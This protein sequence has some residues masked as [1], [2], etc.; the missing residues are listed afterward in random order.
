LNL[1]ELERRW[2]FAIKPALVRLRQMQAA[3]HRRRFVK[4]YIAVTGSCGK[5]TT[6]ALAAALLGEFGSATASHPNA[7]TKLLR[8]IRRINAPVDFFVQ[9]TSAHGPGAIDMTTRAFRVDVA[10]ITSVGSDHGARYRHAGMDI[11]DAIALEKGKLVEAV[12]AGGFACLNYDDARVRAM[13]QRTQQRVIGFGVAADAELRAENVEARW[14][15][16]L[17]FDL[18]VGG[19]THAVQTRFVGTMMLTNILGALAVVHGFGHDLASSVAKLA[20][21]EPVR[22]RMGVHRGRDGKTYILDTEKAPL[23]STELLMADLPRMGIE[24]LT[25]VLGD[26]SD[27]R[28]NNSAHYRRVVRELSAK[29]ATVVVAGKAADHAARLRDQGFANIVVAPTAF[30]VSKYLDTRPPGGVVLLKA[31]ST[32]QLWRVLEQVTPIGEDMAA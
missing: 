29:V 14:P 22:D 23:W 1:T 2:K 9:E 20:T 30:D 31:N 3:R 5:T 15:G 10:V 18:V 6:T 17:R 16:R 13:G 11:P 21:I 19:V 25:F 28:N 26:M 24:D 4:R 8:S 32:S 7:G 27:I 12:A